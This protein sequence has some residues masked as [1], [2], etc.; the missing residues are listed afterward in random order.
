MF[1]LATCVPLL[2][3]SALVLALLHYASFSHQKFARLSRCIRLQ[4]PLTLGPSH[5]S[6]LCVACLRGP[7]LSK[8]PVR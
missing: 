3:C 6:L 8:Y 7:V 5:L 2:S 4:D 1:A